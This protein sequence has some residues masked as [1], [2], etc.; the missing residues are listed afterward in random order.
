MRRAPF[1]VLINP[2]FEESSG[3]Q[4]RAPMVIYVAKQNDQLW[5]IAKKYKTT[6]ETIAQLNELEDDTLHQGEKLL[7][8]K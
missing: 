2:A 5:D 4:R 8:L 3:G 6:V 7:I 1:K